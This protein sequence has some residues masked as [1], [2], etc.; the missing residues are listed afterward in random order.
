MQEMPE[1]PEKLDEETIIGAV[2]SGATGF[3]AVLRAWPDIREAA[4]KA[5]NTIIQDI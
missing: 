5:A 4:S 2:R 1:I 3:A